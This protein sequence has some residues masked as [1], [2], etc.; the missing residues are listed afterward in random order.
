MPRT[1]RASVGGIC[2]HVMN[3]GNG[4]STVFHQP[5]DYEDFVALIAEGCG[6]IPMRVLAYCLMP[7]HFHLVLWPHGDGDLGRVDAMGD[8]LAR[9]PLPWPARDQRPRLAGPV[10]GVPGPERQPPALGDALRRAKSGA[11]KACD[12]RAAVGVWSSARYRGAPFGAESWVKETAVA[13]GLESRRRTATFTVASA[14]ATGGH[15]SGTEGGHG[16]RARPDGR[17]DVAVHRPRPGA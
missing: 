12:L 17:E 13:L 4:R 3:R 7:N 2:Y 9:P 14:S 6:R 15:A 11:G 8:D 5:T 1:R 16:G 10:Q